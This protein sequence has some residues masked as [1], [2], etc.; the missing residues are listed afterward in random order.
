MKDP[1]DVIIRP[2]VSEKSYEAIEQGKYTFEVAADSPKEEIAQAVES[3]FKVG[4]RKVNTMKMRPKKKRQ[5][6]TSGY[7][8]AWKKAIVTLEPGQKIELFER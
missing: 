3:I 2:V 8:R 6:Y 7:S 5:G 4:V 1:R